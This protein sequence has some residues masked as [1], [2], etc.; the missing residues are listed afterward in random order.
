MFGVD[1]VTVGAVYTT[2]FTELELENVYG[3]DVP[4]SVTATTVLNGEFTTQSEFVS[5]DMY[6]PVVVQ[7]AVFFIALLTVNVLVPNVPEP[8]DMII[9]PV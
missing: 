7:N 2:A 3:L 5:S 8:D 1:I 4:V 9:V 6:A